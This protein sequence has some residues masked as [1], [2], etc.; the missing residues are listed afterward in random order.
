MTSS[1]H[2]PFRAS[3]ELGLLAAQ[4]AAEWAAYLE[5]SGCTYRTYNC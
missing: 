5:A 1:T 3:R 2:D 4:Y